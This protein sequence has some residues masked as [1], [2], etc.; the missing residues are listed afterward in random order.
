MCS[1]ARRHQNTA[2]MPKPATSR[3]LVSNGAS[4]ESR[5]LVH[6]SLHTTTDTESISSQQVPETHQSASDTSRSKSGSV[7]L[8]P[9]ISQ[10][11]GSSA[12]ITGAPAESTRPKGYRSRDERLFLLLP[13]PCFLLQCCADNKLNTLYLVSPNSSI[14][15]ARCKL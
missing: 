5:D 7:E 4:P 3:K 1:S 10:V 8:L 9:T 2:K 14:C 12:L 11:A 13:L 6:G 15:L